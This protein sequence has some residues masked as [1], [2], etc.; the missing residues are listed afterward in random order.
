MVFPPAVLGSRRDV[1]VR[2]KSVRK[3]LKKLTVIDGNYAAVLGSLG[4][5]VDWVEKT[6][7][8]TSFSLTVFDR[9]EFAVLKRLKRSSNPYIRRKLNGH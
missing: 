2:S 8:E 5:G 4:V 7:L 9:N 1:I 3:D 6:I